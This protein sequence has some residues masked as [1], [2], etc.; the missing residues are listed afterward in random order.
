MDVCS[1]TSC[2]IRNRSR[3]PNPAERRRGLPNRRESAA[4]GRAVTVQAPRGRRSPPAR[5]SYRPAQLVAPARRHRIPRPRATAGLRNGPSTPCAF[6]DGWFLRRSAALAPRTSRSRTPLTGAPVR[7]ARYARNSIH[8]GAGAPVSP[9]RRPDRAARHRPVESRDSR[10]EWH[11]RA[12]DGGRTRFEDRA[13]GRRN[14]QSVANTLQRRTS[15]LPPRLPWPST[16]NR[17]KRLSGVRT[18]CA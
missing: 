17:T 15:S 12:P 5:R 3:R 6:G 1:C 2:R 4:A 10:T 7:T 16:A 18:R 11:R 14:S 9:A 13:K 8:R